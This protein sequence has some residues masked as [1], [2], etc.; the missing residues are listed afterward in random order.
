MEKEKEKEKNDKISNV[1]Y[2]IVILV[3]LFFL[4]YIL[5]TI[6]KNSKI[7]VSPS[8]TNKLQNNKD[9][10]QNALFDKCPNGYCATNIMTGIKRCPE[11]VDNSISYQVGLE[12]CNPKYSC[13]DK[14][15][16]YA[17]N[18][19][20]EVNISGKC[21][22]DFFPCKCV[23]YISAPYYSTV[24]FKMENGSAYQKTPE[25]E[26]YTLTQ[27]PINSAIS[28][29]GR[30]Q[31]SIDDPS[32][33]FFKINPA[34]VRRITNACNFYDNT[35]TDIT[36]EP[37]PFSMLKC[38]GDNNPCIQGQMSYNIDNKNPRDFCNFYSVGDKYLDDPI[39]YTIGCSIGNGC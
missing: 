11:S 15:T 36:S 6:N 23:N 38:I 34:Y 14:S 12:V 21:E 20:G 17:L 33:E 24:Y 32:S 2:G 28:N 27:L 22:S 4:W 3:L 7:I 1:I 29:P 37:T 26:N 18:S 35:L 19:T 39:F 16:P 8:D 9:L 13:T 30:A 10:I 31:F 25:Y 5:Y